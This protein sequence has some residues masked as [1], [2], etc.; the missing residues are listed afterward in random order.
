[1]LEQKSEILEFLKKAEGSEQPQPPL[2]TVPRDGSLP[3]S[4]AQ[5]RL[6]FLDQ[7]EPNRAA[8]NIPLALRLTG[9][10]DAAVL[11]RCLNEVLR[12]HESLRTCFKTMEGEAVQ[13]IQPAASLEMPL[14]DLGGLPEPEREA[15]AR[16]LC[17]K[18]AQRP[19]NLTQDVLLRARLFQLGEADTFFF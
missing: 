5:Q 14:V 11:Q 6:W 4:F 18:E 17:S 10:L 8:Y 2:R 3:L 19:F 12:R 13:V 15:E 7:F 16:R 9:A 1:M